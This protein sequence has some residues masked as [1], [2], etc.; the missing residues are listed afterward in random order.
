[1]ILSSIPQ[2]QSVFVDANTLIYHFAA[3]P[4]YGVACTDFVRRFERQEIVAICST[5]VVADIA[6]RLMTIDAILAF[7]WP[8][9]GIAQRLRQNHAEIARLARFRQV[10]EQLPQS[11]LQ[12]FPVDWPL[13]TAA[14]AVSQRYQLL[15][16]DALIVAVMEHHGLVH[17]A[18]NDADFDRVPWLKRYSPL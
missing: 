13:I 8:I 6:H 14:M 7:G 17:L 1:M 12:V 2:G 9:T 5:H 18:S 4:M 3:D 11:N 10:V 16:G 15:C